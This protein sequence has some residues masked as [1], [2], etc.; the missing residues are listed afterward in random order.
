MLHPWPALADR[1]HDQLDSGTVGDVGRGQVNRQQVPASIHGDMAFA[2]E[3]LLACVITSCFPMWRLDALVV[4]YPGRRARLTSCPLPIEQQFNV[5][6]GPK[7][8]PPR[9]FAEPAL[10][11]WSVAEVDRQHAP[12]AARADPIAYCVDHLAELN[13][14]RT[15]M[16]PSSGISGAIRSHSSS[17]TS[18][19]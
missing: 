16:R 17:V 15:T 8:K 2:T 6:D 11:R 18:D 14:L 4:D 5:M 3:D 12:A 9:Q 19:G 1:I 13:F 10:V 7:Q